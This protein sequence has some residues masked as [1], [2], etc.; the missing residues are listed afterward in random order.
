M[1]IDP[2]AQYF[3]HENG[4]LTYTPLGGVSE[5]PPV[6]RVWSAVQVTQS[7]KDFAAFLREAKQLGASQERLVDLFM[8]NRMWEQDPHLATDIGIADISAALNRQALSYEVGYGQ[9][10]VAIKFSKPVDLVPLTPREAADLAAKLLV[11]ADSAVADG[12]PH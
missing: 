1:R 7:S 12:K 6:K 10:Q 8:K 11:N 9:G 2:N 3:L 4:S 5:K